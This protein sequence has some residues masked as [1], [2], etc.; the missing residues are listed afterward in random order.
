MGE[1][2]IQITSNFTSDADRL[3]ER[4][5]NV[6]TGETKVVDNSKPHI[7]QNKVTVTTNPYIVE[8][9]GTTENTT[10]KTGAAK[11]VDLKKEGYDTNQ[12]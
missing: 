1:K 10:T 3:Q 9:D 12:L 4:I 11:T 8:T 6:D 7:S 2:R 5:H